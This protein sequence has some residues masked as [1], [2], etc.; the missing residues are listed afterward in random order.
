MSYPLAKAGMLAALQ[1]SRGMNAKNRMGG[2]D[3]FTR[4]V[5]TNKGAPRV[6]IV[7]PGADPRVV[8]Q[9]CQEPI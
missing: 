6:S 9:S 5:W 4:F 8:E 1:A 7:A 2:F 3:G